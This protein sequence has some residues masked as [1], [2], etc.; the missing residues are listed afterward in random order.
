[1]NDL[2]SHRVIRESAEFTKLASP[3][4]PSGGID[5]HTRP[6][7]HGNKCLP[8]H[9]PRARDPEVNGPHPNG[10]H[11]VSDWRIHAGVSE[12][13]QM[14]ANGPAMKINI[15]SMLMTRITLDQLQRSS[16]A[17]H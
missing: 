17:N 13:A 3:S 10:L 11:H 14:L 9:Y 2:G 1:M 16:G 15:N 4:S 12:L 5:V 7:F 8:D 6:Q